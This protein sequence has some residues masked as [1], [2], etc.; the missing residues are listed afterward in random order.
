MPEKPWPKPWNCDL[1][2]RYLCAC[3]VVPEDR[4]GVNPPAQL[5]RL[6]F[7]FTGVSQKIKL[8]TD[9]RRYTRIEIVMFLNQR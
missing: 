7:C 9:F 4:T 6:F 1:L 3:S 8:A 2:Y 5:N